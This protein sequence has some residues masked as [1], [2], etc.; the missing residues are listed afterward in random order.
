MTIAVSASAMSAWLQT[1]LP[2]LQIFLENGSRTMA[3]G[4]Q[5]GKAP[6]GRAASTLSTS[7]ARSCTQGG[8]TFIIS[9]PAACRP[10]D[11]SGV[12]SRCTSPIAILP[13]GPPHPPSPMVHLEPFAGPLP[14]RLA[15]Q[16][17]PLQTAFPPPVGGGG[18]ENEYN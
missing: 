9:R 7:N 16:Q 2:S 5:S 10:K 13:P 3:P 15:H 17:T 12:K 4:C 1:M 6:G 11:G 14:A 8:K 18:E